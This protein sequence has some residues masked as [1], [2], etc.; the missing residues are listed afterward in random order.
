MLVVDMPMPKNCG[1]CYFSGSCSYCEGYN[2]H[3]GLNQDNAEIGYDKKG[4][5][6]NFWDFSAGIEPKEKPSWCPL[7]ELVR[8]GECKHYHDEHMVCAFKGTCASADWYCSN[9][10]RKE[11]EE[12]LD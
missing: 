1:E 2:D 12:C 5:E 4:K 9:G 10:E 8:C 3:C 11:K 7:R 6:Y